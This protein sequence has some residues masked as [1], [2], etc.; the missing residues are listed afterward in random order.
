MIHY[1]LAVKKNQSRLMADVE[2]LATEA[3]ENDY[4]N[5]SQ[6]TMDEKG[7]GRQEIRFA[8]VVTDLSSIC[9]REL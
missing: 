6:Y 3:L 9:D 8:Y 1:L 4:A 2:R 5:L 7:H